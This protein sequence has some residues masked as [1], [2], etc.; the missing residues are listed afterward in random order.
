MFV[1][2]KKK[3]I[4]KIINPEANSGLN[5]SFRFTRFILYLFLMLLSFCDNLRKI[6]EMQQF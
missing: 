2:M 6:C 4:L 1:L 5:L 3:I